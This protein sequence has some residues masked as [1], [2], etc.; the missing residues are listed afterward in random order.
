MSI[1]SLSHQAVSEIKEAVATPF[2]ESEI[3]A[4]SKIIEQ[5]LITAIRES[6][7]NCSKAALNCCETESD[8]AHKIKIEFNKAQT[9]LIANLT[10][11]R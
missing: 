10:S 9:A 8:L 6:V 5:N 1:K 3:E 7:Q 2:K 11:M 4:I